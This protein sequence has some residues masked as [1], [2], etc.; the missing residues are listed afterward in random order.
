LH[1]IHRGV[2]AV[3]RR[4]LAREGW[5]MAAVLACNGGALLGC[6]PAGL[7]WKVLERGNEV[8]HVWVPRHRTGPRGVR[9]HEGT[10]TPAK[11]HGI[12]V[13]SLTDT[14][15]DL[16]AD[17]D[18][19]S[20]KAAVRRA[21]AERNLDLRTLRDAAKAPA[22]DA[23]K[24]RVRKVCDLW[25]PRVE[26]TQSELEARFY[27]LMAA[28]ALPLP[29]LQRPF[30]RYRSDFVWEAARLV[31]ETDGRQHLTIA[32]RQADAERDRAFAAAGFTV[33]RYV[34]ADVVNRPRAVQREVRDR[35]IG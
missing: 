31:V 25:I 11:R 3:G 2:Y 9:V 6:T 21:V 29:D 24:A 33:L 32:A 22:F 34:W 4:D 27:E 26:V 10:R 15:I 19:H 17:L 1:V 14:L 13:T 12:P 30:G 18:P 28:A 5:W 8:P 7:L 16:A 20:L 23:R 35:L